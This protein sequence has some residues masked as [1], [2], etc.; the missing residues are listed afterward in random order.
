MMAQTCVLSRS[1]QEVAKGLLNCLQRYS[2]FL[3]KV[4][5]EENLAACTIISSFVGLTGVTFDC[6]LA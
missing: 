3:R 5:S 4:T 1:W 6:L 2:L